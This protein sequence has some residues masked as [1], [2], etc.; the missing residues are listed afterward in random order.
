[1]DDKLANLILEKLE[2]LEAKLEKQFGSTKKTENM[3]SVMDDI[4]YIKLKLEL[5]D[6]ENRLN[7]FNIKKLKCVD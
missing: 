6:A 5:L 4:E 3:D 2:K 7:A 1:M